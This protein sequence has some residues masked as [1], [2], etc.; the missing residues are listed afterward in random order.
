MFMVE[1]DFMIRFLL[2]LTSV[3]YGTY[4]VEGNKIRR[5][6]SNRFSYITTE[7]DSP[8]EAQRI[9]NQLNQLANQ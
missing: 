2:N 9:A 7:C 5:T 8:K 4:S 3:K 1:V 6:F